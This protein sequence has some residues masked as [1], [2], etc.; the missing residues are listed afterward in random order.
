LSQAAVTAARMGKADD[1]R[2]MLPNQIRCLSPEHDFCDIRGSGSAQRPVL[3][4]RMTLREGPGAIDAERLGRIADALQSALLQSF[5]PQP[6][7]EPI[8]HLLP[9]WPAQWDARFH[10]PARGGFQVSATIRQ[11]KVRDVAITSSV[12]SEFRLKNP[13]PGS[14]VMAGNR[15]LAG[16]VLAFPTPAG[17]TTHLVPK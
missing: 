7:G 14:A 13:W 5:P 17:E 4:N 1:L 16:D 8:L 2:F 11:G 12:A 9:A 3:M 15:E 6:G 10:L